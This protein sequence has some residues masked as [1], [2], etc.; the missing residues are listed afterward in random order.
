MMVNGEAYGWL[1][2]EGI[3]KIINEFRKQETPVAA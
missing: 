1:T 2:P 3:G